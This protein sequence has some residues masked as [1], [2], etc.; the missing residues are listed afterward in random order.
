MVTRLSSAQQAQPETTLNDDLTSGTFNIT[1]ITFNAGAS[2]YTIGG[3]AFTLTGAVVNNSSVT[4]IIND[5]ITLNGTQT[6]SANTGRLTFGGVISGTNT[7][8]GIITNGAQRTS[9]NVANTYTG[10]T[11]IAS[12]DLVAGVAGSLGVGGTITFAGGTLDFGT[13]QT[14]PPV[15]TTARVLS[16]STVSGIIRCLLLPLTAAIRAD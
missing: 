8:D 2:G 9:F 13:R 12:G 6:F 11:T 7:T 1:G 14:I 5:A 3:N 16:A 10:T 15:F 4:E